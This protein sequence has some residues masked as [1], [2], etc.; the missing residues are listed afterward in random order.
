[1]AIVK[2]SGGLGNQLF[3]YSFGIY[4]SK[5]YNIKVKFQDETIQKVNG[6]TRRN[7]LL[8][9]LFKNITFSSNGEFVEEVNQ[10]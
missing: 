7:F 6:F 2:I 5:K 10:K 1:M 8:M 9:E 4:L 3:Q